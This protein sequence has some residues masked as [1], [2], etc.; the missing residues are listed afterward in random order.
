MKFTKDALPGT[1]MECNIHVENG[2]P[3]N[4]AAFP[5]PRMVLCY[6]WTGRT[7]DF[8]RDAQPSNGPKGKARST[9]SLDIRRLRSSKF[10]RE[11]NTLIGWKRGP[12]MGQV[13]GLGAT[14]SQ[15]YMPYGLEGVPRP[16]A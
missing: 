5:Y 7:R 9:A 16:L 6:A 15:R 11:C 12:R 8:M 10:H 3:M 13:C 14:Q 2:A 4:E 1:E